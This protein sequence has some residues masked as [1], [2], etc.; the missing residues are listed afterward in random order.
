LELKRTLLIF[1]LRKI[2][3]PQVPSQFEREEKFFGECATM[4]Q[5]VTCHTFIVRLFLMDWIKCLEKV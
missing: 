4:A 3:L 5:S 2:L 1:F